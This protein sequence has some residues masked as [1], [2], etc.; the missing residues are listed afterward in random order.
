MVSEIRRVKSLAKRP[1]KT[2]IQLARVRTDS[3]VIPVLQ[4]VDV[5][6]RSAAGAERIEFER[7]DGPL[8]VELEFVSEPPAAGVTLE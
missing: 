1:A 8:N 5:D 2:R 3:A 7:A 4:R 6:L